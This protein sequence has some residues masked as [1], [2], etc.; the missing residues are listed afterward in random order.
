M[1]TTAPSTRRN[2]L[3]GWSSVRTAVASRKI[4]GEM[5]G[6][7]NTATP[8]ISGWRKSVRR[9]SGVVALRPSAASASTRLRRRS[10]LG[11]F[12]SVSP[13]PGRRSR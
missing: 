8:R 6:I 3:S 10:R 7:W 13:G 11:S 4:H 5:F 2:G 9:R 1:R 12:A